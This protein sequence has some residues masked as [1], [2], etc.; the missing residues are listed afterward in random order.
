MVGSAVLDTFL[1]KGYTNII[2]KSREALDLRNQQEVEKFI[3]LEKP[4]AI[5]LAAAKVG[6]I[7]ANDK[8]PYQ[9]LY[10]NLA[11][12]T[13]VINA[14]HKYDVQQLIFL[15]SSCIYPK[16][17]PQP[18]KE[19]YL[20]T[21]PLEPTNQWYAIAKIAG[22][23]LC[24]ALNKQYGRNYIALMPTNLYGPRDN[25]DLETSCRPGYDAQVL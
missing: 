5:I 13:N 16:H 17:A 2:S 22:I 11:I 14:A 12:Q 9:F 15:G 23:K 19:E 18:L 25:F 8:Y 4:D 10:D 6:G 24:Q 1:S 21:G 20:L 7:L 3:R